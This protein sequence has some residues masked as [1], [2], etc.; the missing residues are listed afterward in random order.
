MAF[1]E[2]PEIDLQNKKLI[3]IFTAHNEAE[4]IPFFLSYYRAMGVQHFLAIDNNSTDNSKELLLSQPDVS[5][6]FTPSS[7]VESKA[8]RL[9]TTELANFYCEGKWCLTLDLD[10]QLVFPGCEL[11]TIGDL[12]DYLDNEGCDGVFCVF[13]DMY[14]PGPLSEAIYEP[15]K[16]FLDVCDHF[17][18]DSYRLR[19]P[20]HFPH[21]QVFGGP[22][23]RIFWQGGS[24]GN[25][26]SM[27][28]LPLIKWRK[29]FAY[30]FSTHS[31]TPVRLANVTAALLH[32]KFFSSF[33]SFAERELARGDRVQ[34]EHYENY[35]R[36]SREQDLVFRT[37][38][39]IKYE[40][41]NTLVEN[42]VMTC[43]NA[44]LDWMQPRFKQS[45]RIE[46]AVAKRVYRDQ[47]RIAMKSAYAAAD[48]SLKQLPVV[49][50]LMNRSAD[51]QMLWV[52]DLSIG[53]FYVDLRSFDARTTVQAELEDGTI[54]ARTQTGRIDW[55]HADIKEAPRLQYAAFQLDV[56]PTIFRPG[57][58]AQ[59]VALRAEGQR[60]PFAHAYLFR[61]ARV[62]DTTDFDGVCHN[63]DGRKLR[64][65][66]WRRNSSTHKVS[67]SIHIDGQFWRTLIADTPRRDLIEKGV[68][69]GAHGFT[70]DLP[71]WLDPEKEYRIDVL[72]HATNLHLRRSPMLVKG[73]IVQPLPNAAPEVDAQP[74]L[75][76]L[77]SLFKLPVFG[78]R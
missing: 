14:P 7:Y 59:L 48:L 28:K 30:I 69:D 32:F 34:K 18:V 12:T 62:R 58:G 73:A 16:P 6:F 3:A 74:P 52:R 21:V 8:G 45:P 60:L 56:P 35:A 37:P 72:V 38:Y 24:K 33:K 9:W 13:L 61:D 47:L 39:S 31:T 55:P 66:V 49:W 27:R 53:G 65:W 10:E 5:Y 19:R 64:G 67:V 4:R 54:V 20:H 77:S 42:G 46:D 50:D 23:Q 57:R 25:G 17:E 36:L 75:K 26:P 29:G 41:S 70:I 76:R 44:Y 78:G 22:R 15:G 11:A 51:A 40:S 63:S 71:D 2:K 43:N 1:F 68:G